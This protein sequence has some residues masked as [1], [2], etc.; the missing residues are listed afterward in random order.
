MYGETAKPIYAFICQKNSYRLIKEIVWNNL[1]EP[2]VRFPD[3]IME[4]IQRYSAIWIVL[5]FFRVDWYFLWYFSCPRFLHFFIRFHRHLFSFALHF[6]FI[7]Q[8]FR[9]L[10][11]F[12]MMVGAW[13]KWSNSDWKRSFHQIMNVF[14]I[15]NILVLLIR[16]R[17]NTVECIKNEWKF[18]NLVEQ[19][20]I[21]MHVWLHATFWKIQVFRYVNLVRMQN[22][23]N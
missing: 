18:W 8:L 19:R 14:D 5:V 21:M 9:F 3:R 12:A 4:N 11:N 15:S 1:Q 2:C 6:L 22:D 20:W 10:C 16:L 23:I 13:L 7:L 17:P